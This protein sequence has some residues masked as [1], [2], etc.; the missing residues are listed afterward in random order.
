MEEGYGRGYGKEYAYF[1][2]VS[3]GS[4]RETKGW[5]WRARHLLSQTV[6]DHR[7][8]LL[9]EIISLTVKEINRQT[10]IRK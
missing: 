5:Y 1:L 2:R 4:A 10:R 8:A 3:V 6:L 7:L 9:D